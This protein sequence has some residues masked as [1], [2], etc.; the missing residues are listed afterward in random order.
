[1]LLRVLPFNR[2]SLEL[3]LITRTPPCAYIWLLIEPVWNWNFFESDRPRAD[4][5]LSFNRTSLELKLRSDYSVLARTQQ[6]D[7][8]IEP[9]WNWNIVIFTAW[10]FLESLLIEPVWNWNISIS[11]MCSWACIPFNRTSLE[12]KHSY[13]IDRLRCF[14][15][16]FNRTSLE[17]KLNSPLY[18]PNPW[19]FF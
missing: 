4:R 10:A 7:L 6:V 3:K 13:R 16:T 14:L 8:L 19:I 2:T 1:M 17:L 12:L 15:N 18:A 11:N 9:V 5:V